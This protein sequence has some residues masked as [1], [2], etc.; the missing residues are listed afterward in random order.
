M[1]SFRL[2]KTSRILESC[3]ARATTKPHPT[4]HICVSSGHF[5][6]E[7]PIPAP[8]LQHLD[9]K[10]EGLGVL[11]E[12]VEVGVPQGVVLVHL[13]DA[14]AVSL[15]LQRVLPCCDVPQALGH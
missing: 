9:V 12:L 8:H 10:D 11:L 14:A 5:H 13:G 7:L 6:P 2:E 15:P 3:T 4:C 1:E